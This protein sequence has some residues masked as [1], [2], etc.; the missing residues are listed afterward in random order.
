MRL[1]EALRQGDETAFMMLVERYQAALLRLARVYISDPAIA[2]EVVQDTWVG[3]LL[4]LDRF[5][6]R[7][8]LKTWIFRILMNK[9]KTR[10]IREGRVIPFSALE[11]FAT[12]LDGPSVDPD[13]FL[14]P[15]DPRW[16]G[17]WKTPPD[18]WGTTPEQMLLSGETRAFIDAAIQQLRPSQREVITLRDVQGLSAPEACEILGISEAN[19]RVLLHRARSK[20]RMA[21][22]QF[23]RQEEVA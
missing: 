20:V 12:D 1:I 10:A 4:G 23:F 19:Q 6:G 15:D 11:A 9:A 7:S 21:L 5:E 14:P 18:E 8:S 16:P 17:H 13:R 3:V 2:E 22:E